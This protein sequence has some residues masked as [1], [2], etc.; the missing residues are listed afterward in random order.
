MNEQVRYVHTPDGARL[1]LAEV[2]AGPR[3]GPRFLLVHGFAQNRLAFLL[4][5]L[6]EQLAARGARVF[7]G[8]LR[9]HGRSRDGRL[10]RHSLLHHLA[11]DLPGLIDAV[12]PP[13]HLIGHSMGGL[14]GYALLARSACLASLTTFGAPLLLGGGRY[15]I[16]AASVL[17]PAGGALQSG[18][19]MDRFL[20]LL[21]SPLS[22]PDATGALLALQRLTRLASPRHASDGAI[23]TILA[24]ADPESP[25]IFRELARMA[26]ARRPAIGGVELERALLGAEIPVAT[27]VGSDDVFGGRASVAAFDRPGHRGPRMVIEVSGGTHV[28][29]TIGHHLPGTIDRLWPFLV[30]RR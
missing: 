23:A 30:P 20:R 5:A 22:R 26:R 17:G 11:V 8:E 1:A 3:D 2:G 28:D 12:G 14:L 27:V 29:I 21:A 25:L 4:G 15:L 13:V 7:I 16:R 19:P 18:V 6:P 9:G 24:N 10:P